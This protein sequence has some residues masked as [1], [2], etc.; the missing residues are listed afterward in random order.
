MYVIFPAVGV[1]EESY[2]SLV[3]QEIDQ[4]TVASEVVSYN[5]APPVPPPQPP[6]IVIENA[7]PT[8]NR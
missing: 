1:V 4:P 5:T 3:T 8:Q 7:E 2:L 6:S